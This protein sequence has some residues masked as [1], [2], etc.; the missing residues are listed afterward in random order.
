MSRVRIPSPA[1]YGSRHGES[2]CGGVGGGGGRGDGRGGKGGSPPRGAAGV[3]G[4]AAQHP[5]AQYAHVAQSVERVLG[6]DEVTSSI[7]VVGSMSA[8]GGGRGYGGFEESVW[9]RRSSTGRSPT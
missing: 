6:K 9:P 5:I 2:R 4:G 1:P 3:Q 8:G 7:L